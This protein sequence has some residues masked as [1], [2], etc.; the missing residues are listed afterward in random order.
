MS[1]ESKRE[2][3]IAALARS[4][5]TPARETPDG[6]KREQEY[7]AALGR[8]VDRFAHAEMTVPFVLRHY[9]KLP[10]ATGRAL[11]SGVRVDQAKSLLGRL[12]DAEIMSKEDWGDLEPTLQHLGIINGRRNEILHHG[13]E[14]VAEGRAFVTNA[15]MALTED[16]ITS[17]AISPAILD[18]MTADLRKIILHLLTRHTGRPEMKA[19]S[20]RDWIASKLREPWR[21]KLPSSPLKKKGRPNTKAQADPPK[22]SQ[23]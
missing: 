23:A 7:H 18:D 4:Y 12:A 13:A 17:F 2:E 3:A 16:R 21:Y 22:P 1:D 15:L 8:F 6:I 9:A 5:P 11:L 10:V 19:Q 20:T 14:S